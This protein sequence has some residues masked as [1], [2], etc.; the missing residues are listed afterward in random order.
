MDADIIEIVDFL[1]KQTAEK[2]ISKAVNDGAVEGEIVQMNTFEQLGRFEDSEGN[3]LADVGGE[4]SETTQEIKGVGPRDVDLKDK[5]DYWGSFE[6]SSIN[7]GGYQIDS[8]PLKQAFD[9]GTDLTERWGE[10][11]EG[12]NKNNEQR[13]EEIIEKKVWDQAQES[14]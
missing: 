9:G 5:G 11:I 10:D 1:K 8:D 7:N 2:L 3:K 4:Y 14:L 13:A 6:V 12:L